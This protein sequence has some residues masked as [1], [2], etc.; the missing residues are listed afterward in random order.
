MKISIRLKSLFGVFADILANDIKRIVKDLEA[1][2]NDYKE[3]TIVLLSHRVVDST[4]AHVSS[5]VAT[6]YV[7]MPLRDFAYALNLK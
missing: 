3:E 1:A 7:N 2:L 4:R 5:L 6:H